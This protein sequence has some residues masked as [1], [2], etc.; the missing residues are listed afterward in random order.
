ML[1]T[2]EDAANALSQ[3]DP[4]GMSMLKLPYPNLSCRIDPDKSPSWLYD[5]GS[6]HY[7][8]RLRPAADS[9]RQAYGA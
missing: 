5:D 7:Q 9:Q 4:R 1:M 6:S 8:G 3:D 2:G